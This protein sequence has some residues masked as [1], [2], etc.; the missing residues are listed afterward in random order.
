M[1]SGTHI[2]QQNQSNLERV[3]EK[4]DLDVLSVYHPKTTTRS[5]SKKKNQYFTKITEP[6]RTSASDLK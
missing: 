6:F 4:L 3:K 2:N 5:K 1:N